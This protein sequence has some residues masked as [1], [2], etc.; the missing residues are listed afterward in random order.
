MKVGKVY[1]GGSKDFDER[2]GKYRSKPGKK[3]KGGK[4][5][6][7]GSSKFNERTGKYES[8]DSHGIVLSESQRSV[9][10]NLKKPVVIPEEQKKFK[11]KPKLRTPNKWMGSTPKIS[12]PAETPKQYKQVGGR[13]QWG[14][15][16]YNYNVTQSQERMNQVYELVGDGS[17]AF[18]YMLTDSKKLNDEQM[19]KFWGKNP[20]FYSYFYGG[21]KY[22]LVR[23]EQMDGD[24][25][26]FLVDDHGEKSNILQSELNEKLAEEQE[27]KELEEYNK[28]NSKKEPI[29]FEKDYMFKRAYQKLKPQ[30]DYKGKPAK[31]G[32]P[33][34][35]PPEMVNNRH[36][37][38]GKA[39]GYYNK[40]DPHS[41]AAMP[42][43][44]NPEIDAKAKDAKENPKKD[45]AM[46]RRK[47][48]DKMKKERERLN[49]EEW[50]TSDWRKELEII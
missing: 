21:K 1:A 11:V 23:K 7:G 24:F 47:L 35:K 12:K 27:M 16:E 33:D 25:L 8:Y 28:M 9:L 3:S 30:V 2:T 17:M 15:H 31:K 50:E 37:D 38:F 20:D 19:E 4:V 26:V 49:K 32:Y 40:L 41:A 48:D 13:N 10:R 14:R 34:E 5:W 44:D 36:P 22:K 6:A 46:F 45:S 42:Q 43:Q 18:D 39:P 29:S